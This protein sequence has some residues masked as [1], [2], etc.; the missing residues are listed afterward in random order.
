MASADPKTVKAQ[1][2]NGETY[3]VDVSKLKWRP[4]A[5]GIVI[6]NDELLLLKQ[7]NGYDLPGG[8]VELG[9]V[10]EA[11]VLREITE[12]TGV[13]AKNPKLIAVHS[14]FYKPHLITP[15]A[16]VQSLMI[17]YTC[18][19]VGGDLSTDGFDEYERQYAEAPE[20]I[21]LA[22]L[23]SLKIGTSNDFRGYIKQFLE[24]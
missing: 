5:Y 8:G 4:S 15:E 19:Y 9:E 6:K 20:W 24:Q 11:A 18:E 22:R 10:P 17:Y 21:S 13:K 1:G 23:D 14:T 12:E 3:E 2:F 7:T 16:Y